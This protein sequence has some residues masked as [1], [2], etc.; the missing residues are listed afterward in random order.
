MGKLV[1]TRGVG[2]KIVIG[3]N[4]KVEVAAIRGQKV[5]IAIEAPKDVRINREE[6]ESEVAT[7]WGNVTVGA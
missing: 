5:R 4:V 1:L 6:V 7:L 2:E 3:G